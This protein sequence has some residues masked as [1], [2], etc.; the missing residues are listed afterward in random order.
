[1]AKPFPKIRLYLTLIKLFCKKALKELSL[2]RN[3]IAL[4]LISFLIN[5]AGNI[6]FL[7][8]TFHNQT[9][10]AGWGFYNMLILFS[11]YRVTNGFINLFL[12]RNI[13]DMINTVRKGD[14]DL[15]L[16]RP[17]S[18]WFLLSFTQMTA[19]RIA[20]IVTGSI[21][22]I[23]CLFFIQWTFLSLL[24]YAVSALIGL[25]LIS[26]LYVLI[27]FTAFF[28]TKE[29]T[30]EFFDKTIRASNRV[31]LSMAND[32]IK[33][34]TFWILPLMFLSTLPTEILENRHYNALLLVT[35]GLILVTVYILLTRT[36]WQFCIK[37]YGS[38]SS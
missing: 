10:I 14:L 38:A 16:I 13:E 18:P 5:T 12:K 34:I 20:D 33:F 37:R 26:C 6:A 29:S 4:F 7:L 22:I 1:M 30:L 3:N 35:C 8:I 17:V 19:T 36:V 32:T 15:L 9:F 11:T 25:T 31:P 24:L 28:N 23:Y 21:L 2:R 27:S